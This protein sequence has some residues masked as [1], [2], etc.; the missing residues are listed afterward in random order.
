MSSPTPTIDADGA[1]GVELGIYE[2]ALTG[3]TFEEL[4]DSAARA[5]FSFVDL[6]VD[7]SDE[8]LARLRWTAKE[9]AAVRTAAARAGVAIGG[10]CL[11]V[12]RSIAPGSSDPK[13]RARALEVLREGIDLCRDLGASVLQL[14]GYYAYYE[15]PRPEARADYIDVFRRGTQ[16]AALRGVMLGLENVD[17]TDVTSIQTALDVADEIDSPWFA[18]YP[19]IGNFTVQGRDVATEIRDSAGS[20]LAWHVKDARRD[21]PRRVPMGEGDVPWDL[22]FDELARQRWSGRIMIEMWNDDAPDSEAIAH[23]AGTFIRT[24]LQN[25]GIPIIEPAPTAD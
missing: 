5:G 19:D 16:Y 24:R 25:A 17:G 10:V 14:A 9:R 21:E 7:E 23:T 11:S 20:A 22:A 1:W 13:Q 6:S 15:D 12:H 2:K 3:S 18:L 4:F 8:R